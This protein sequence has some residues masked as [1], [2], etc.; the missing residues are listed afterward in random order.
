MSIW[1]WRNIRNAEISHHLRSEFERFGEQ[2][3]SFGLA[4]GDI[5]RYG[6]PMFGLLNRE[7]EAAMEWLTEQRDKRERR[8]DIREAVGVAILTLL[9][10]EIAIGLMHL[11]QGH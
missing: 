2:A 10:V 8:N 6:G 11:F 7:N 1:R 9:T 5:G 4:V 3:I